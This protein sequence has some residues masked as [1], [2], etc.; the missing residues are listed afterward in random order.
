MPF[1]H[2]VRVGLSLGAGAIAPNDPASARKSSVKSNLRT[3]PAT[4]GSEIGS[5]LFGAHE[6]KYLRDLALF[7]GD[8]STAPMSQAPP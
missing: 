3:A 7:Y 4:G 5:Y 8:S 1:R 6:T 2:K